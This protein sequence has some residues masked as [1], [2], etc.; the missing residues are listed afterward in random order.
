MDLKETYIDS[1]VYDRVVKALVELEPCP[2]AGTVT[3]DQ[4]KIALGEWLNI[5]R[6]SIALN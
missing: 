5:W 6:A 2:F 3:A 4:F 1:V